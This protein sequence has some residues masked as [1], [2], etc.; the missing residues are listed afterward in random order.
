MTDVNEAYGLIFLEIQW[1]LH[2]K[3]RQFSGMQIDLVAIIN[4]FLSK[5]M[6]KLD[7]KDKKPYIRMKIIL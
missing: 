6:S 3:I 1:T 7:L 2:E 4:N 5:Q